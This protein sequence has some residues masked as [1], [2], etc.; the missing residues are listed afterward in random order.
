M[1]QGFIEAFEK[2][3][4]CKTIGSYS[5]WFRIESDQLFQLKY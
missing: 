1:W 2:N 3:S 5:K 4:K